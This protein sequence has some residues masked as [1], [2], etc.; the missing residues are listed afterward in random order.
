VISTAP[1]LENL[2]FSLTDEIYVRAPLEATFDAVLEQI[3]PANET[4]DRKP[5][6]MGR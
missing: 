1:T 3:G 2:D 6:P 5:L 4:P